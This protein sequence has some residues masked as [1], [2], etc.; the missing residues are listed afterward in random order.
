MLTGTDW[1]FSGGT[2]N[3]GTQPITVSHYSNG[4]INVGSMLDSKDFSVL[5]SSNQLFIG[6]AINTGVVNIDGAVSFAAATP[7]VTLRAQDS[8]GLTT[9]SNQAVTTTT[10]STLLTLAARSGIGTTSSSIRRSSGNVA[11]NN[12]NANDIAL[13]FTSGNANLAS[14]STNSASSGEIKVVADSG[15]ITNSV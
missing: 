11:A 4:T 7:N 15:N 6:G 9:Q 14:H 13:K 12:T 1:N 2:I 5:Q 3:A 10:P 8:G